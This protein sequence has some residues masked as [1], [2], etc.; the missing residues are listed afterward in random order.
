MS[1]SNGAEYLLQTDSPDDMSLWLQHIRACAVNEAD[2]E[3]ELKNRLS[4]LIPTTPTKQSSDEGTSPSP[5]ASD[6]KKDSKK[7]KSSLFSKKKR[8]K[9]ESKLES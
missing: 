6:K 1:L 7:S 3:E 9:S 8:G 5:H 2:N 4:T